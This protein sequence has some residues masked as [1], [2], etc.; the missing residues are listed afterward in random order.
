M[1]ILLKKILNKFH[2]SHIVFIFVGVIITESI[3]WLLFKDFTKI[4]APGLSAIVAVIALCLA[5]YSAYQVKKWVSSKINEKAFIR[6]VELLD[7]FSKMMVFLARLKFVMERITKLE[8]LSIENAEILKVEIRSIQDSYFE[9]VSK[10]ILII[11]TF[12]N[13]GIVFNYKKQFEKVRQHLTE[14][15]SNCDNIRN[16]LHKI[17]QDPSYIDKLNSSEFCKYTKGVIGR[18]DTVGQILDAL[19][20]MKYVKLFMYN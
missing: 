2:L 7:E 14:I 18:I 15:Q 11:H 9:S 1:R 3:T 20:K 17:T 4:T 10:Q 13:W 19:I 8:T 5:I 12:P 16:I 6:S